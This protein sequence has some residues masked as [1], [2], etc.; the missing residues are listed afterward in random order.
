MVIKAVSQSR[1]IFYVI[2]EEK[3]DGEQKKNP[4]DKACS[5]ALRFLF[6]KF[7]LSKFFTFDIA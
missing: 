7:F 3:Y 2:R 4:S 6:W 5:V 1:L